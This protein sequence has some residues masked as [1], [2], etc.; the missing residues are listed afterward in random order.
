MS[1]TPRPC[2][3]RF[4]LDRGFDPDYIPASPG[5]RPTRVASTP[6]IQS[7]PVAVTSRY[8]AESQ[9]VIINL[10]YAEVE[11]EKAAINEAIKFA[12]RQ[13][14]LRRV[15]LVI[16]SEVFGQPES[17]HFCKRNSFVRNEGP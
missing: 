12:R 11:R 9:E 13:G 17:Y 10:Q 16:A 8:E 2:D 3:G 14:P 5:W 15:V 1:R 7:R 6:E 4:I